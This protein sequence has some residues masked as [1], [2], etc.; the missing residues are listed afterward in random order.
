MC[1][2]LVQ[3][4]GH[5]FSN[6]WLQDFYASNADGIGVMY[7]EDGELH[8]YKTVPQ[9]FDDARKFYRKYAD[10]K[11]CAV[12]W[13][14]RTHGDTDLTN[15]HP[16]QVFNHEEDGIDMWLMHNGVL[17]TG[18][19]ADVSKSDTWHYI[20]NVIRPALAGRPHEFMSEWFRTL[21]EDHIGTSNK[22]VMLDSH[23][24]MEVF[25]ES[26]GVQWNDVWM[27]N[28]YAWSA[29]KAGFGY[30]PTYGSSY[31]GYGYGG[32]YGSR[33][34]DD[35]YYEP[36]GK[37]SNVVQMRKADDADEYVP[38]EK[39]LLDAETFAASF[40]AALASAKLY[41]SYSSVSFSEVEQLYLSNED[42]AW[43]LLD[44]IEVG[45]VLDIDVIEYF[46]NLA[47]IS[48]LGMEAG[49]VSSI[50]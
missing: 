4:K 22:F 28:T 20:K 8:V 16:Y 18:N 17:H 3:P 1:L 44:M 41:E 40:M 24:N 27:S 2:L 19:A 21:V 26:S 47:V 5:T 9:T 45:D 10:R 7:V 11:A 13:R 50:R 23:G 25:N 38:T 42:A 31:G 30:K 49:T 29:A 46:D 12:H 32:Y 35:D 39:E 15:C 37:K 33:A 14:M 36:V 48:Q 6:E 43:D 34:W